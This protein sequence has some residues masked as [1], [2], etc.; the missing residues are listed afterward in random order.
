MKRILVLASSAA[1]VLGGCNKVDHVT[2]GPSPASS[3]SFS[4]YLGTKGLEKTDFKMGD[5]FF[6]YGVKTVA[7]FDVTAPAFTEYVFKGVA[8]LAHGMTVTHMGLEDDK[9]LWEYNEVAPWDDKKATFFAVSPVPQGA[10][11]YGIT[12]KPIAEKDTIPSIDFEVV[13][14]Y[15]TGAAGADILAASEKIKEQADLM[16][17]YSP[18][19]IK[20]GGAIQMSFRH[21]L[22]QLRFSVKAFHTMGLLRINSVTLKKVMTKG[23]LT[24]AH[25][26]TTKGDVNYLGGWSAASAPLDFAVNLLTENVGAIDPFVFIPGVSEAPIPINITDNDEALMMIPQV[27]TGIGLEVKYSYSHD[28]KDWQNYETGTLLDYELAK[29]SS[30]WNPNIRYNY[31][32]NIN[33]GKAITF[34]G[35]IEEWDPIDSQLDMEYRTFDAKATP[36]ALTVADGSDAKFDIQEGDMVSVEYVYDPVVT[37]GHEWLTYTSAA[38]GATAK[39]LTKVAPVT[40][41]AAQK[42]DWKLSVEKN[43]YPN[44]RKAVVTVNRAPFKKM[45]NGVEKSFS[46][47]VAKF[48]VTQDAGKAL[49]PTSVLYGS[50][51]ATVLTG[52]NGTTTNSYPNA[53]GTVAY[54][55]QSAILAADGERPYVRFRVAKNRAQAG[56]ASLANAITLLCAAYS[57]EGMP[58]GKWRV[59]RLAE[60]KLIY[61]NRAAID[62]T[63]TEKLGTGVHW[64]TTLSTTANNYY[65]FDI[66]A[67]S[68]NTVASGTALYVRCVAEE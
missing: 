14:G 2:G 9:P 65:T 53:L 8:P 55:T 62:L 15:A 27:L 57:E 24:L 67:G 31:C 19:N 35:D 12:L 4:T 48:I 37:G 66:S 13:G 61:L 32:L 54:A 6:T 68:S 40:A 5:Q 22:S 42:G 36:H 18:N 39:P 50:Q 30:H 29:L 46:G 3:V 33:P 49:A 51:N 28:G 1:L 58:A 7:D 21:A 34:T 64:S 23:T 43:L 25:D 41:T 11:N 10:V 17:A 60:L 20:T 44:V 16:W 59:P 63:L 38:S 45:I 26:E 52:F 56:T 47:G